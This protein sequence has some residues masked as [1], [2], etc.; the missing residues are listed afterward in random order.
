[1]VLIARLLRFTT[2][3]FESL[4]MLMQSVVAEDGSVHELDTGLGVVTTLRDDWI[5]LEPAVL[6]WHEL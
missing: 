5:R 6:L 4:S 2:T 1:M 3:E